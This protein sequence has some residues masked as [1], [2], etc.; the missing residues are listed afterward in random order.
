[1]ANA[2]GG[3]GDERDSAFEVHEESLEVGIIN[4]CRN[5]GVEVL[6]ACSELRAAGLECGEAQM[7]CLA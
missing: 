6:R 5:V 1:V 7:R 3:S 4:G 2:L